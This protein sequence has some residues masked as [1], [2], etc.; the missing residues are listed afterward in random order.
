MPTEN[1]PPKCKTFLDRLSRYADGDLGHAE[2]EES[3]RH[4]DACP[5]CA[6][7]L[8][9]HKTMI[10]LLE[11]SKEVEAPW[12]LDV[13]VLEA[14]GFGGARTQLRGYRVSPPVVWAACVAAMVLLGAGGL[15]VRSGIA[16]FLTIVF[17]PAGVLSTEEMA[18]LA[19]KM[20]G[21]L[22]TVWDGLISGLGTFQPLLR[23]F[24]LVSDAAKGNPVVIGTIVATLALVFLFFRIMA[25]GRRSRAVTRERSPHVGN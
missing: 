16:R 1:R 8:E 18:G 14:V 25:Q 23:S 5:K 11:S 7:A 2:T 12:D 24:G 9:S 19:S 10:L 21:Y 15:A 6:V 4:L 3:K 17:G 20:T 13:K 22:L